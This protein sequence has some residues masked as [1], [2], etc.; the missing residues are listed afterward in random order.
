[1]E[2][3]T[4]TLFL[5]TGCQLPHPRAYFAAVVTFFG[6]IVFPLNLG[7]ASAV[8]SCCCCRKNVVVVGFAMFF[9]MA[10]FHAAWMEIVRKTDPHCG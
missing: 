7:T 4:L 1:M 6:V 10:V 8:E 2:W 5:K 3:L 9:V